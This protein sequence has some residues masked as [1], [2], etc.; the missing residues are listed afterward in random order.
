MS[1][2][3]MKIGFAALL[4]APLLQGCGKNEA[5]VPKADEEIFPVQVVTVQPG[6]MVRTLDAVGTVRYRRETPLGFTTPGKV[7]TVRY[8]EG[9]YVRRGVLLAALD[10]TSVGADLSVA[11]AER[12]R[13]QAEFERIRQLYAEG[14]VTK[15]RYEAAET[16]AKAASAR[17]AQAGFA[18]GTAQ[19]Y[20][21]SSGVILARNVEPGQVVSAGTAVVILGQ[22]DQ[23]F[24]FRAPVVDRDA[25]RLRVGMPA[26]IRLEALESGPLTATISEIEGQAN[27]ATGAFT[28]QFRLPAQPKIR[29]GQIGTASIK[30]PAANDGAMQIPASALFGVR[31]GEGLVY[32]VDA[33]TSRV[34][35]RNVV[36]E[37]VM[38]DFVIISGGLSPG[39]R[40][41]VAGAEKLR[42]GS[43][44]RVAPVLK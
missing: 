17:V 31:T 18:R 10:T 22:A 26:E 1:A 4:L 44:V 32:I 42:T 21:P 27:L 14:W 38:D 25:A 11:E 39:D 12:N 6:N 40:I 34:E 9:D 3:T 35:T 33:S 5:A 8:E 13:A 20:A 36:I 16:A 41:V 30:L 2:G 24:V 23:G 37:R 29:A 19:L 15:A 43:K 28:V 7:A